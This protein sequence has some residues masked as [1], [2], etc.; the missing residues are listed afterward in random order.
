M[1]KGLYSAFIIDNNEGDL[2]LNKS[3]LNK[4]NLFGQIHCFRD[5]N[6]SLNFI[7]DIKKGK[8]NILL[9]MPNLIILDEDI[10]QMS[11]LKFLEELSKISFRNREKPAVI[12]I[13]SKAD[14]TKIESAMDK[15]CSAYIIKP[16]TAEKLLDLLWF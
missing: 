16:L 12:M 8:I 10:S 13:S 15:G 3:T 1:I 5:P 11:A 2:L 6:Q 7:K 4:L 9:T 14:N